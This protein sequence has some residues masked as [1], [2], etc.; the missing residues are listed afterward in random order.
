MV[1]KYSGNIRDKL[2]YGQVLFEMML[3]TTRQN[4]NDR[5]FFNNVML[6][7]MTLC[8]Y[9]DDMY[10]KDVEKLEADMKKFG[11]ENIDKNGKPEKPNQRTIA[12]RKYRILMNL[13]RRKGLLP[14]ENISHIMGE[15][16]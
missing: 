14:T 12:L 8:A 11:M 9:W 6:I 7:D 3:Q 16:F 2:D 4:F 15:E 13:A 1:H 5:L 10:F